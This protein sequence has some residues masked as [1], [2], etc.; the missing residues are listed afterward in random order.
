MKS[1]HKTD[2][3]IIGLG[4]WGTSLAAALTQAGIPLREVVVRR[5]KG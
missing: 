1:E 3:A 4:N 5:R 2:V